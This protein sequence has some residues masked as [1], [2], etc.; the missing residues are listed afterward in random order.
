MFVIENKAIKVYEFK[1]SCTKTVD[2]SV[3]SNVYYCLYQG[4][5]DSYV[6]VLEGMGY[7]VTT[8]TFDITYEQMFDGQPCGSLEQANRWK[9]A[10]YI[11]EPYDADLDTLE[12]INKLK[13][14]ANQY[15]GV[16]PSNSGS[17]FSPRDLC[18]KHDG[19]Y[20]LSIDNFASLAIPT[21]MGYGNG[22]A[23]KTSVGAVIFLRFE[24]GYGLIAFRTILDRDNPIQLTELGWNDTR[25]IV[26]LDYL[27]ISFLNEGTKAW[28]F[29]TH[30][31]VYCN[32]TEWIYADGT[33]V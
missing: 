5:V 33:P 12:E 25:K 32:G 2:G 26:L 14:N 10:M 23:Y 11:T 31:P 6:T 16:F 18:S 19:Y 4:E 20:Y 29:A 22:L 15:R 30:R 28:N 27:K 8:E 13:S 1:V 3:I 24:D 21:D 17:S 7:T 9:D